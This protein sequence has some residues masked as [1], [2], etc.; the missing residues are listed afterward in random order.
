M[1]NHFPHIFNLLASHS[2]DLII[3]RH[4]E[5]IRSKVNIFSKFF[6]C[7]CVWF[8]KC[9]M[10]LLFYHASEFSRWILDLIIFILLLKTVYK[11][12]IRMYRQKL[13]LLLK[14]YGYVFRLHFCFNL[15]VSLVLVLRWLSWFWEVF[16]ALSLIK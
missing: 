2:P 1:A 5:K 3:S 4:V 14:Q 13:I 16:F 7:V 10:G 8:V 11:S 15:V 12:K 6:V 9:R